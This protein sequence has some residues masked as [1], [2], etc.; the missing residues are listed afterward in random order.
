MGEIIVYC[1]KLC[2]VQQTQSPGK[3]I[4]KK[5]SG[6]ECS[7][8]HT[9]IMLASLMNMNRKN[10]THHSAGFIPRIDHVGESQNT[11]DAGV[12][13]GTIIAAAVGMMQLSDQLQLKVATANGLAPNV[14]YT[15]GMAC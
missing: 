3:T 7:S 15:M 13:I 14:D 1:V 5:I 4:T 11:T 10:I 2:K 6:A 9:T 8:I 12:D